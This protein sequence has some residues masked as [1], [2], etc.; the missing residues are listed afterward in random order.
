MTRESPGRASVKS[1]SKSAAFIARYP[2]ARSRGVAQPGSALRSGRRG[3]QFKSGHPDRET[4]ATYAGAGGRVQVGSRSDIGAALLRRPRSTSSTLLADPRPHSCVQARA[5]PTRHLRER[6]AVAKD[7]CSADHDASRPEVDAAREEE[8]HAVPRDDVSPAAGVWLD[9]N[10]TDGLRRHEPM[11]S[12][13][14]NM[15]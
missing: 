6:E 3:P 2:M 1:T 10:K 11:T 4:R 12:P 8:P 7:A 5:L 14:I 15:S 13:G 9:W